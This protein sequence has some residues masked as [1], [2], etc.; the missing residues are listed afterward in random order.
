MLKP[1][2][3]ASTVAAFAFVTPALA[4]MPAS[5][6]AAGSE[7]AAPSAQPENPPAPAH[8]KHKHK[9]HAAKKAKAKTETET[10]ATEKTDGGTAQ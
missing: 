10:P 6:P 8:K 2:I 4:Q 9:K 1:L 7:Q 3:L 5:P